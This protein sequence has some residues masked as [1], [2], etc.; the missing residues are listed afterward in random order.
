MKF[1]ENHFSWNSVIWVRNC[2][3]GTG[4]KS[5]LLHHHLQQVLIHHRNLLSKTHLQSHRKPGRPIATFGHPTATFGHPTVLLQRF[6]TSFLPVV[7]VKICDPFWSPNPEGKLPNNSRSPVM[8]DSRQIHGVST[9]ICD[10]FA[11][12]SSYGWHLIWFSSILSNISASTLILWDVRCPLLIIDQS[13]DIGTLPHNLAI[14][15]Y[16]L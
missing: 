10:F 15:Y 2:D 5:Y 8:S 16:H 4:A 3:I 11:F 12:L 13:I 1:R 6:V 9:G 14:N 7:R